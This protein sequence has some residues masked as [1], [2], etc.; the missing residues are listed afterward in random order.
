MKAI[1]TSPLPVD[2]IMGIVDSSPTVE[3][4]AGVVQCAP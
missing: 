2:S 1:R 3:M 4:I